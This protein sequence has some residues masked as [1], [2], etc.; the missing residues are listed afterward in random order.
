MAWSTVGAS[1]VS[2][3]KR[4]RRPGSRSWILRSASSVVDASSRTSPRASI[5]LSRSPTPLPA[6]PWPRSESIPLM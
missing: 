1:M 5:G 3:L 6:A 2:T 4:R